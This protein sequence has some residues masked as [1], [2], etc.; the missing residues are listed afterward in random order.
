VNAAPDRRPAVELSEPAADGTGTWAAS[1]LLCGATS[2]DRPDAG[3]AQAWASWH[4]LEHQL[5]DVEHRD[6]GHASEGFLVVL[7]V[8][9]AA[10]LVT[11][12]VVG[13]I[14]AFSVDPGD[15]LRPWPDVDDGRLP[16]RPARRYPLK[17]VRVDYGPKGCAGLLARRA[18]AAALIVAAALAWRAADPQT[19]PEDQPAQW[20]V[21]TAR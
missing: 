13:L 3:A 10:A 17:D 6:S 18:A 9:F 21:R 8:L 19:A 14:A 20:T 15:Q 4:Q 1:C 7:L 12:G 2:G 5:H 16:R 11:L